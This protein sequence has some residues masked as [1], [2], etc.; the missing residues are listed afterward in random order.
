VA[1]WVEETFH[2]DWRVALKASRILYA[3]TTEHQH[4]VIFENDTWGTVLM[5]D[6]VVQLTTADE[7][8]YHEMMAHVPL[9]SLKRPQRVLVIGGGDGGVLRE[10]LKHPSVERAT[11]CEIDRAVID[12]ALKH[13]PGVS[14]GAFEDTRTE[15]VIADG[16][17]YLAQTRHDYDAIIVDSSEPIGPSARLHEREFFAKCKR[18]LK[19]GGILVSQT[20]LPFLFPQHLARTVRYLG[21]LFTA[22]RPYLCTQPSYFGGPFAI[23]AASDDAGLLDVSLA[24]LDRRMKARGIVTRAYTPAAHRAAFALPAYAGSVVAGSPAQG[25][26]TSHRSQRFRRR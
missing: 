3:A 6:G 25:R 22:V 5:L 10:V 20:G 16:V 12:L 14:G 17:K 9:M 15:I 7:F 26:R 19:D 13:Y 11:L 18:A 23:C 4:L 21:R 2:R 24:T 8:I 1:C